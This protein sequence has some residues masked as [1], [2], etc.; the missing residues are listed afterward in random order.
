MDHMDFMTAS[1]LRQIEAFVRRSGQ[2]KRRQWTDMLFRIN[3]R[4]AEL[5][6]VI[7]K[8]KRRLE[9][10]STP[11]RR[12][13]LSHASGGSSRSG[14]STTPV[15]PIHTHR[16]RSDTGLSDRVRG[17][18]LEDGSVLYQEPLNDTSRGNYSRRLMLDYEDDYADDPTQSDQDFLD[19]GDEEFVDDEIET[20]SRGEIAQMIESAVSP[21]AEQVRIIGNF[22]RDL[23]RHQSSPTTPSTAHRD[24][25]S[26]T[27][28]GPL[29]EAGP[30]GTQ[31]QPHSSDDYTPVEEPD[32]QVIGEQPEVTATAQATRGGRGGRGGRGRG[33]ATRGGATS[34]S[35]NTTAPAGGE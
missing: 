4:R 8:S 14:R 22:V 35:T 24:Q 13:N 25:R 34:G 10:L 5:D 2:I 31:P 29:D 15:A 27:D 20:P 17:V 12:S 11:P 28:Q 19:D 1:D 6:E 21:M 32:V 7:N 26:R 33:G 18:Q 23:K 3:E 16:R 9:S 30:S